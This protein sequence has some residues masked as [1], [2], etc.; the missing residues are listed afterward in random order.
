MSSAVRLKKGESVERALRRLKRKVDKEDTLQ[1]VRRRRF[2]EKPADKRRRK[3]KDAKFLA[4]LRQR[5][6]NQW[7]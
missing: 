5:D 3:K 1:E 4:M 6:L 7:L 2:F